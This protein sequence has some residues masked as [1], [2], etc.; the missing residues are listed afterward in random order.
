VRSD[1]RFD[2]VRHDPTFGRV[3]QWHLTPDA[4]PED[5]T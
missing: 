5:A 2:P 1:E 4:F 3:L